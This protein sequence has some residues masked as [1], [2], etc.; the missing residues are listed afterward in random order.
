LQSGVETYQSIIIET[1]KSIVRKAR[2]ILTQARISEA[3]NKSESPHLFYIPVMGTGFTIDTPLKVARF[4]ITSVISLVDDILIEQMRRYHCEKSGEPYEPVLDTDEDPRARRITLYLDLLDRLV[5][6]QVCSLKA[7]PFEPGS[8]ITRYFELLPDGAVRR[9]YREMLAEKDPARRGSLQ[10][11]LRE[12]VVPGEIDV[13]IMTKSDKR[14]Y[15][16]GSDRGSEYSDA[17]AALRGFARS[18][19]SSSVEFSAGMNQRLYTYAGQFEDFYPDEKGELKKKVALK[20]SDLRSAEIQGKFLARRGI[21]ISEYRI[22]SGLNCGGH[23]FP[24]TGML[25]G[26]VLEQLKEQKASL[27]ATLFPLYNRALSG[28]GRP[29]MEHCPPV[30][31]TVQGGIGTN[32]EHELLLEYYKM[33][34]T[35]WGTPFLLVPEATN[36]DEGHLKKLTS[37]GEKDVFLSESSPLGIPFWNLRD[38]GSE[39]ARVERIEAGVPGS[40]C[41][42]GFSV[43]NTEFT[44]LPICTASRT[45]QRLKLESLKNNGYSPEQLEALR[46]SVLA[47]SC[48]CH[49]LS[50]GVKRKYGIE[51]QATP[52]VCCGPNIVNLN[53]LFSLREL[54]DHIYGRGPSLVLPGRSHMFLREISLY[55][56]YLCDELEK[57]SLRISSRKREYFEEFKQNLLDGIDYYQSRAEKLFNQ[58]CTRLREELDEIRRRLENLASEPVTA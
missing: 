4:G 49:D 15:R 42:K 36:L 22:E 51:P 28:M 40:Y 25:L 30:R 45:Y 21:W 39:N 13:N 34:R 47:K 19:L 9:M 57:F 33:N 35:G 3:M 56:D 32:E 1:D 50:G 26:P 41:S 43:I 6:K 48:I 11:R 37:A 46:E 7:G 16:G 10:D 27:S 23:A 24:T 52:A 29:E 20:V 2:L 54:V 38:S 18:G 58:E 14:N 55:A 53:R 8:D 12:L 5:K 17:L 31:Y 44:E